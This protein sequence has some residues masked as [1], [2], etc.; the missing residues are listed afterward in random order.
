MN[1]ESHAARRLGG[2]CRLPGKGQGLDPLKAGRERLGQVQTDI[3]MIDGQI[4]YERTAR[5][6]TP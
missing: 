1:R 6:A 5:G 4:A 2:L 3:T